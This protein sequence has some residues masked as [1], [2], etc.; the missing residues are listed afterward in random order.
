MQL[1]NSIKYLLFFILMVV[2]LVINSSNS[3]QEI[4]QAV[5]AKVE[6]A[7]VDTNK[8]PI[9]GAKI[10]LRNDDTGRV[11][12]SESK[13]KGQFMFSFLPPGKYSFLIE[14]EGYQNQ[15]GEF[16]LLPNAIQKVEIMLV[17]EETQEQKAEKEAV[18]LFEKGIKLAGEDK[19][20]EA[21]QTF[22]KLIELKPGFVEAHL[23]IGIL[24]FRQKKDDDAEKALLKAHELKPDEA[25]INQILAE[26]Y[27]EKART[28]IQSDKTDEA[29]EKLKQAFSLNPNHTYVNYLM[30]V[31]F[32]RKEM[33]EEAVKHFEMFLQ[34]EPNS[35]YA[36]KV[37]EILK[38][39]KN[40]FFN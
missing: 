12:K 35:P 9:I 36:E 28:L 1:P 11:F 38:S 15:T 30:G 40:N 2:I 7:V 27:Y 10:Q 31:L 20:D 33:K 34:L 8:E 25:K 13:T 29:L 32:A 16:H 18:L 39:L 24:Y 5:R 26:V 14:K 17:K 3:A 21:I 22:Q 6:G 37:K 23:N 4:E 19:L